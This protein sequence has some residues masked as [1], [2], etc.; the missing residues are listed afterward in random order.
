MT[1]TLHVRHCLSVVD[2]SSKQLYLMYL[3]SLQKPE[4]ERSRTGHAVLAM[5]YIISISAMMQLT[6][7]GS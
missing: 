5:Q 6:S 2:Y 1:R 4:T 3:S 7:S